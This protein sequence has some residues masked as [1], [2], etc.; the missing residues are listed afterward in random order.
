MERCAVMADLDR[1]EEEQLA[2]AK[3]L[4]L[5]EADGYGVLWDIIAGA[6]NFLHD[7]ELGLEDDEHST[8]LEYYEDKGLSIFNDLYKMQNDLK[9]FVDKY[10]DFI[11]YDRKHK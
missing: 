10:A 5:E 11:H 2:Y 7:V 1:Y 8:K 3:S 4:K 6:E 9:I